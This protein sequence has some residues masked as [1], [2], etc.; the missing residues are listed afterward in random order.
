VLPCGGFACIIPCV[1]PEA[2]NLEHVILCLKETWILDS[3][4]SALCAGGSSLFMSTKERLDRELLELAPQA[5]RVRVTTHQNA[6]E[7]R[8]SVW[9]GGSILGSLGSFHQLWMS[10]QEY[11]EHGAG[12]IHRK[13]P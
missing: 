12:L 6:T 7:R 10:K 9:L 5:A 3:V 8:F 1:H 13:S 11:E 4:G 2:L